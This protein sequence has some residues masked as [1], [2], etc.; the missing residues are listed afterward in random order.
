MADGYFMMMSPG[1]IASASAGAV[2][3]FMKGSMGFHFILTVAEA[4][5][6]G[7]LA[8]MVVRMIPFEITSVYVYGGIMFALVYAFFNNPVTAPLLGTIDSM[9]ES[10]VIRFKADTK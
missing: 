10:F 2:S 8:D 5:L 3:A 1:L 6:V 7:F 9:L 4:A